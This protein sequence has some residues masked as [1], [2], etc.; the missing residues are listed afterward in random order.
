MY[1]VLTQIKHPW[2]FHC[3]TSHGENRTATDKDTE[4]GQMQ[5]QASYQFKCGL[6]G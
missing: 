3:K 6:S 5:I 4:Q 2:T 1:N